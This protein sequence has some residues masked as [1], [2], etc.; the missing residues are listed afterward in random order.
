M[1]APDERRAAQNS[2]RDQLREAARREIVRADPGRRRR[3]RR[4]WR[5]AGFLVA[6]LLGVTVAA[7]AAD[8]ISVGAPLPDSGPSQPRYA[9]QGG[10]GVG[11]LVIKA[12]D[13]EAGLAWGVA[14]YTSGD[15]QDCA[16]AGQVRGVSLGQVRAGRF[17]PYEKGTTGA[18]GRLD[19]M[20]IWIDFLRIAGSRPR[21]IVYGRARERVVSMN[22]RGQ[23]RTVRTGPGGAF[24]FV[25]RGVF[26]PGSALRDLDI[27]PGLPR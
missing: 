19:R 4:R 24:V 5:G 6:A 27:R 13:P 9:P 22:D 12:P 2:V 10:S 1:K 3:N 18:C 7:G 26:P 14:I 25:L 17:R 16:I 23:R 21:T 15:G 20:P 11:R 8:L